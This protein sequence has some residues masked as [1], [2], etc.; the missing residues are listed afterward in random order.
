M[1]V[2]SFAALIAAGTVLLW[3]PCSQDGSVSLL[4]ALFTS[5]SAVCVTGLVVVDT[6]TAFT[7]FGQIVI[8]L[9]IQTGGLGVMTF[10]AL[11][12]QIF[13]RRLSLR[14]QSVLDDSLMQRSMANE[15]R[16][17]FWRILKAVLAIEALGALLIF[18]GVPKNDFWQAAWSSLFHSVSAFCNAG[19]S[20]YPDN[21]A[22]LRSHALV[23]G[24]VMVLITLGGIGH[25]VLV[26]LWNVF[27]ARIRGT[28]GESRRLTLHTRVVLWTSAIL[29]C[30]GTLMLFVLGSDLPGAGLGG[31]LS[32]SL[33]HSV[34][35]RTAGFNTVS[36]G[37]LPVASVFLLTLLMF[38][39]GSPG[40][41][42]GGIKTTT[43]ALW[44]AR[45]WSWLRGGKSPRMFDRHISGE[46][47][48]RASLIIGLAVVWNVIG[49][50]LLS[51]TEAAGQ[52][53]GFHDVMFEQIS[54]FGTVGLSTGLTP[55]LSTVGR[56]WIIA[57]MFVGRLGTITLVMWFFTRR[58][59]G[60]RYPEGRVMIG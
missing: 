39:G 57:S 48:R 2:G 14:A 4:D 55:H 6:G 1:L 50:L 41:C 35:A 21:L 22:G 46:L 37:Q 32:S 33:F 56:L 8:L 40:S 60:I 29:V 20:I 53:S 54:A 51:A 44:S 25:P 58:Q 36:V 47:S 34:S 13:G 24:T 52:T 31:R 45:L 49:V 59:P 12:F 19:F 10:A 26:D 30:A 23:T 5:T 9:L 38:V 17:L 7:P 15:F 3:L 42:A 18:L 16:T 11:A 43:L 28:D 27:R